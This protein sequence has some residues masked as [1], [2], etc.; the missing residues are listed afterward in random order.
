MLWV[1]KV[2]ENV[3]I[4]PGKTPVLVID[5]HAV[6]PGIAGC[7]V[8]AGVHCVPAAGRIFIG[9]V[10][11][12]GHAA[13]FV[14][15]FPDN[16]CG[17]RDVDFDLFGVVQAAQEDLWQGLP[18]VRTNHHLPFNRVGRVV[19]QVGNGIALGYAGQYHLDDFLKPFAGVCDDFVDD[20]ASHF[21]HPEG[22][23]VAIR[24]SVGNGGIPGIDLPVSIIVRVPDIIVKA[25]AR[26]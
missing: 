6:P 17:V 16:A 4:E 12:G 10:I 26:D 11:P 8:V 9:T 24:V 3:K 2:L 5:H 19:Y 7:K 20:V 1:E 15:L 14:Q 23:Q 21:G 18:V 13:S 22:A 25:T